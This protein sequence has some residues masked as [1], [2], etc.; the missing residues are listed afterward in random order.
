[1]DLSDY[2]NYYEDALKKNVLT[3]KNIRKD[4]IN[5]LFNNYIQKYNNDLK[6]PTE[7]DKTHEDEINYNDFIE[8]MNPK[9]PSFISQ[10]DELKE[11]INI[12]NKATQYYYDKDEISKEYGCPDE[13][14]CLFITF[15]RNKLFRCKSKKAENDSV[16]LRHTNIDNTIY[17]KEY[18]RLLKE[19]KLEIKLPELK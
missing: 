12:I 8:L 16:C 19:Y 9:I 5:S 6:E 10:K 1:M 11:E 13:L 3:I 7:E 2:N 14:R 15:Q 4:F 17:Q 18:N